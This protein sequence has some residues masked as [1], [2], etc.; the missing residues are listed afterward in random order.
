MNQY[1]LP[2]ELLDDVEAN[3]VKMRSALA[4]EPRKF[5]SSKQYLPQDNYLTELTEELNH[6]MFDCIQ[7]HQMLIEF[8]AMVE[9]FFSV[10]V[11]LKSFQCTFQICNLLFTFMK[12]SFSNTFH[13]ANKRFHF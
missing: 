5:H 3:T 10:F 11:L 9:D 6:A 2:A 7:Q 12:V 1:Y 8:S 13:F 4:L